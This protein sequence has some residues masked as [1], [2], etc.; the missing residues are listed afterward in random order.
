MSAPTDVGRGDPHALFFFERKAT[1]AGNNNKNVTLN[2]N[3]LPGLF[4]DSCAF[5]RPT[6]SPLALRGFLLVP[7]C[8]RASR[9]MT[10]GHRTVTQTA[11]L[12]LVDQPVVVEFRTCLRE[13]F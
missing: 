5:S 9:Q 7:G 12:G 13:D 4:C 11:L 1:L 10:C 6:C 2:N 8:A 3:S